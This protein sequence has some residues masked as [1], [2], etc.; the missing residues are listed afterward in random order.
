MKEDEPRTI[1]KDELIKATQELFDKTIALG[2]DPSSTILLHNFAGVEDFDD[3]KGFK[4]RKSKLV[5]GSHGALMTEAEYNGIAD[6]MAEQ[7]GR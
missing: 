1:S 7:W 5:I 4:Y 2:G 6:A 3:E